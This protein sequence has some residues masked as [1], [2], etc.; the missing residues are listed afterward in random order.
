MLVPAAKPNAQSALCKP[1]VLRRYASLGDSRS[2]PPSKAPLHSPRDQHRVCMMLGLPS[3]T[4]RLPRVLRRYASLGDSR[5]APPSKAPLHSPRVLL[6]NFL[7]PT[8]TDHNCSAMPNE[9]PPICSTRCEGSRESL[10]ALRAAYPATFHHVVLR[11]Y[12]SLGDSLDAP[13]SK[14]PLHTALMECA[15][16]NHL[17]SCRDF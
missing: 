9:I 6:R 10:P 7:M 4:T 17:Y 3:A 5:D 2:A 15:L 11:R 1:G 13:P 12:A 14:A 16:D 8:Q